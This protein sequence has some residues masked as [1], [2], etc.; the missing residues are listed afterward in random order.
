VSETIPNANS[1]DKNSQD[2]EARFHWGAGFKYA[3][4]AGKALLLL[5]GAAPIAILTFLGNQKRLA[6][7]GLICAIAMFAVG[8]L[9]AAAGLWLAYETQLQYGNRAKS[10]AGTC[11]EVLHWCT[12]V[13]AFLSIVLFAI[14]LVTASL[15]GLD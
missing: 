12:R 6:S 8:A 3:L 5:N 14:G 13:A 1:P 2:K 4:E 10:G 9:F 15:S 11:A 7:T